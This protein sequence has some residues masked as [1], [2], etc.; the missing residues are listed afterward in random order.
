MKMKNKKGLLLAAL[1]LGFTS[2]AA[3]AADGKV[4]GAFDIGQGTAKD[5]CTGAPATIA[6]NDTATTYRLALGYQVNSNVGIEGSYIPNT[7]ITA[8]GTY[9]GFPVNLEE[10]F[11]AFQLAAIGSYP[12]T[13]SFSLL[14]KGGMAFIDAKSSGAWGGIPL[15]PTSYNNT[16][17]AYGLG[18]RFAISNQV[19][20]R[21]MYEDF[22]DVKTSSSGTSGK[23]T[24]LSAGLQVG[25]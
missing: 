6:C 15:I 16:N 12:A 25:F 11:S 10:S 22:G 20:V 24:L 14:V 19:T 8:S 9:L 7:K 5:A 23:V 4:Y 13:E 2:S 17:F 3:M 18:A 1:F 21:V